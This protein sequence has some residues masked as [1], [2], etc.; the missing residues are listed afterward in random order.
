[1]IRWVDRPY[2]SDVI[3]VS[4]YHLAC[5]SSYSIVHAWRAD[6]PNLTERKDR[7][8]TSLLRSRSAAR[9][10]RPACLPSRS[11]RRPSPPPPPPLSLWLCTPLPGPKSCVRGGAGG[12]GLSAARSFPGC[13]SCRAAL[14]TC[15]DPQDGGE[16][17]GHRSPIPTLKKRMGRTSSSRHWT[18]FWPTAVT[19][20][21]V[22]TH[23][24]GASLTHSGDD[25][26][27]GPFLGGEGVNWGSPIDA[28]GGR[29]V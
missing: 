28:A 25:D 20:Y 9:A 26:D 16:V 29:T 21:P 10:A 27:D 1:M 3:L 7:H 2:P 6:S 17:A 22:R 18:S 23:A 14:H 15:G 19:A 4:P 12:L 11:A 24:H 5:N 13:N 8:S